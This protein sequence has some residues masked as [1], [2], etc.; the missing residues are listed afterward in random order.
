MRRPHFLEGY[1]P[2][3]SLGAKARI[4]AAVDISFGL[5]LSLFAIASGNLFNFVQEVLMNDANAVTATHTVAAYV[6][7]GVAFLRGPGG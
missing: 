1:D 5:G 6:W 3:S 4:S 2:Q 7:C